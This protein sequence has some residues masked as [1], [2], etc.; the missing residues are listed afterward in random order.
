MTNDIAIRAEGVERVKAMAQAIA[1]EASIEDPTASSENFVYEIMDNIL[2][3]ET[4]EEVYE[5]Q[6]VGTTGTKDF[7]GVAFRLK[8]ANISWRK[9]GMWDPTKPG[10]FPFFAVMTVTRLDT[11]EDEVVSGGGLTFVASLYRLQQLNAFDSHEADGGK[12]L[13][14]TA[15]PTGSGF[16]VLMLKA[17]KVPAPANSRGKAKS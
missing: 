6:E 13:V 9:S 17:Y 5:A 10:S 7:V 1:I 14:I 16:H 12:P 3:A 2:S 15:K 4:E 11:G 8:D